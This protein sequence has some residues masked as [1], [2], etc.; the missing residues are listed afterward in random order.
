LQWRRWHQTQDGE[1]VFDAVELLSNLIERLA[2]GSTS[3]FDT[4]VS[5]V[6]QHP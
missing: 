5:L 2:V 1:C 3:T 4:A 6:A